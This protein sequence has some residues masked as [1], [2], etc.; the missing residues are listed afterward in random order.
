MKR[1]KFTIM[2]TAILLASLPI[3]LAQGANGYN[4]HVAVAQTKNVP[5]GTV[6]E[7]GSQLLFVLD[8]GFNA[9]AELGEDENFT[10]QSVTEL[11]GPASAQFQNFISITNTHPS[12]SVTVHFRYFN[13][14]CTDIID[15]LVLLTCNDTL[16]VDPFNLQIP[17][18]GFNVQSRFF[19][20]TASTAALSAI[21]ASQFG[22]GRFLL[23]VT[24]SGDPVDNQDGIADT[25]YPFELWVDKF[26]S[27]DTASDCPG[28]STEW[29][30]NNGGISDNNLHI[31]NASA[32]SFDYLTGFHTVAVPTGLLAGDL[33]PGANDLAYG[34]TAFTRPS[35]DLTE[36]VPQSFY[37]GQ[38]PVTWGDG[39]GPQVPVFT[40]LSGSERIAATAGGSNYVQN[41]YYLRN[42]V[43]GGDIWPVIGGDV[44]TGDLWGSVSMGGALGWT[45]FPVQ[46]V[47]EGA[48]PSEQFINFVSIVDDY[49]GSGNPAGGFA[50]RSYGLDS[51]DTFYRLTVFNNDE[52]ALT[53]DELII[54]PPPPGQVLEILVR[55][56]NAFTFT[57]DPLGFTPGNVPILQQ[58][59]YAAV[60]NLGNFS[61]ED[62]FDVG[63]DPAAN[64][65]AEPV[66]VDSE[67]GPGWV[68]FDR[69]I[70][71]PTEGAEAWDDQDGNGGTYNG[72]KPS[73][74]TFGQNVIRFEGF[75]LSYFLSTSATDYVAE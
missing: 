36:D 48:L 7:P 27:A 60:A 17:G 39:D 69:T 53:A 29:V 46:G 56:I 6:A 63:G 26:G 51:A 74:A 13:A 24:A 64:F 59:A 57:G 4:D 15:F 38:V 21:P 23:F 28:D 34:V 71:G 25:R 31:L 1:F 35:V 32:V 11:G 43:H 2:L 75:G 30:G 40:V 58:G 19:G 9:E 37:Q 66:D 42:D 20:S 5:A 47:V 61:V 49:D 8:S 22:D 52:E 16:L 45:L 10:S 70:T 44:E 62:L 54:S 73:F 41:N 3:A 50:D 33:P 72:L 55:C 68:R 18:T 12:R 65:L 14:N 67:L